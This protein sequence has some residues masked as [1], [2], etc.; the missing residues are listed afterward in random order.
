MNLFSAYWSCGFLKVET[1]ETLEPRV[2]TYFVWPW[3][4]LTTA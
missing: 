2:K 3:I 4:D 1:P